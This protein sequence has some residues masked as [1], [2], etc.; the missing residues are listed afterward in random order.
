MADAVITRDMSDGEKL[1]WAASFTSS[2]TAGC[3]PPTAIRLATTCVQRL[4]KVDITN[5]PP[6]E[7]LAVREMRHHDVPEHGDRT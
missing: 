3:N 7:Q 1:I 2:I 4:R 5:L 6:A